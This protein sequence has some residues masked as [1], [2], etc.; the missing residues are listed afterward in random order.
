MK[1]IALIIVLISNLNALSQNLEARYEMHFKQ[2]SL[3]ADTKVESC[4]LFIKDKSR[5][6]F[7]TKGFMFND[8]I[9]VLHEN[10]K[11]SDAEFLRPQN[12][13][14]YTHLN[15]FVYKDYTTSLTTIYESIAL[16]SYKYS[17]NQELNWEIKNETKN[18]GD[19][20]CYKA[21]TYYAGRNYIA[22]FTKEIPI[23]DGPY[24][25]G[26]LP[27]LI[28]KICDQS[29]SYDFEL[30]YIKKYDGVIVDS[31]SIAGKAVM[32]TFKQVFKLREEER[33]DPLVFLNKID[34][35]HIEEIDGKG[36][37]TIINNNPLELRID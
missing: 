14:Y 23:S 33:K 10:G 25:F 3:S 24:I 18:I 30:K 2:D 22:W 17:L 9:M 13:F 21:S 28:V 26:G 34:G 4:Y 32:S 35:I 7:S 37:P 36:K 20:D 12:A 31:P 19:Y 11:L 5:S 15:R 29:G 6:F 1:K 27:G 8:S 16:D